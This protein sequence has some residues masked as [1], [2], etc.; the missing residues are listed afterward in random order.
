MDCYLVVS[1]NEPLKEIPERFE[2]TCLRLSG[3]H[4]CIVA[5]P[6]I[7]TEEV[8]DLFG[9]SAGVS[10]GRYGIVVK[11]DFYAGSDTREVVTKYRTLRDSE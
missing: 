10:N 1:T 5:D 2:R 8:A 11:L 7:K 4:A 9:V 3:E 6:S